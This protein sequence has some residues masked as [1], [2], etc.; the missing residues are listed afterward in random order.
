MRPPR[1]DIAAHGRQC[2][3]V[4]VHMQAYRPATARLWRHHCLQAQ[5]IEDFNRGR[6]DAGQ[7]GGLYA[8]AQH[9]YFAGSG[10]RQ[11][12][13]YGLARQN[14]ALQCGR[15]YAAHRL[16]Q[17][18]A[19][20]KYSRVGNQ[21]AQ[22]SALQCRPRFAP[23]LPRHFFAPQIEQAPVLHARGASGFAVA[24]G[25]A[26]IQMLLYRLGG[27]HSLKHLLNL[28]NPPA[29]AV[30]LVAGDL[31][32]GASGGAKA[33]MHAAAQNRFGLLPGFGLQKGFGNVGLHAGSCC[34]CIR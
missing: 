27:G 16:R 33:A 3:F 15:Q 18:V 1:I 5:C 26:A 29:R 13:G 24:A 31:I 32:G 8:A 17:A 22:Q 2:G 20:V 30:Q 6:I 9:Q 19:A 11:H 21:A 7:H 4:G 10:L 34:F 25:K 28:V 23:H 12:G 14:F